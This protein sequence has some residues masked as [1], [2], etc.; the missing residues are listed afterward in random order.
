MRKRMERI[1]LGIAA[2]F[3]YIGIVQLAHWWMRRFR[4]SLIILNYHRATGEMLRHHFLYLRRYYRVM[5]LEDALQEFSAPSAPGR[6]SE[7]R[8]P[9]VMTFDDGYHDNYTY[10]FAV[11]QQLH[12]PITIFLV[13]GYIE[14]GARFWWL[15]G[16]RLAYHTHAEKVTIEGHTYTISTPAERKVLADVIDR[17][18]RYATSIEE[19]EVFLSGIRAALIDTATEE[20]DEV[21]REALPVSWEQVREMEQS[22]W[23]SFGAHTVHHPL[24]SALS[25]VE[26]MRREVAECRSVLE[27]QLGHPVRS[28]AYPIGKSEQ[29][30]NEGVQAVKDAGYQWAVTTIEDRNDRA[31]DRYLLRRLPGDLHQHWLIMASELV[32]LLGW[33]RWRRKK[34]EKGPR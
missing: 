19:R 3:Y 5:H 31:T 32:G 34:L 16:E 2:C 33:S 11:A 27:Q 12:V 18:L 9:V 10:A 22:G 21:D 4:P 23:V 17:H 13:P 28:F 1:R 14:S 7:R 15:E 6:G 8:L 25:D 24:L 30:G 29:I 26:E 20:I